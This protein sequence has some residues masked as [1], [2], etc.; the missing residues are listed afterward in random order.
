VARYDLGLSWDEFSDLT[1]SMF[2]A[3][4]K[5]RNVRLKHEKFA[6]AQTAAAVYNVATRSA[7][8]LTAYDFVRDPKEAEAHEQ[9]QTLKRQIKDAVIRMPQDTDRAKFMRLRGNI[10]KQLEAIGRTDA[11]ELWAECWPSL[12][13]EGDICQ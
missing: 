3:L 8:P 7:E 6:N 13:P 2:V 4:C 9:R 12:V 1:P 5:R 11:A 10:I